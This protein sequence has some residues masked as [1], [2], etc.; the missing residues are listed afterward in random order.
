MLSGDDWKRN[1]FQQR[2]A[3][4]S[5]SYRQAPSTTGPLRQTATQRPAIAPT[6]PLTL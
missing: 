1:I 5:G 6:A 4:A 3:E 2:S